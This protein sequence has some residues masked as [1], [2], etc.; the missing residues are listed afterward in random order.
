MPGKV[1]DLFSYELH[2]NSYSSLEYPAQNNNTAE[3]KIIPMLRHGN[4]T[5]SVTN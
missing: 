4:Y 1:V 2:I 3:A 5:G